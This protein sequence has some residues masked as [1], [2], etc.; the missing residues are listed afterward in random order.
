MLTTRRR[1]W[2]GSIQVIFK[3]NLALS[4]LF[5]TGGQYSLVFLPGLVVGRLFD[6]G[7]FRLVFLISSG[8]LVGATFLT[9]Q[10]TQYWQ[11]LLCQGILVGVS[12][13]TSFDSNISINLSVFV[14][15]MRWDFRPH[16]CCYCPLVQETARLGNGGRGYGF[17]SRRNH[18][19]NSS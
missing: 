4:N 10:C 9:A 12:T 2:I 7:Y 17:L 3:F 11:F 6:L 19:S 8:V 14:G 1:A 16:C 13:R 5:I 18:S 15:S